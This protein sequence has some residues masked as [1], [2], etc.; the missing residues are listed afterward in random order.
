MFEGR[1]WGGS[2]DGVGSSGRAGDGLPL[3]F[4]F[5]Y[6]IYFWLCWVSVA[7]RAFPSLQR[8]RAPLLSCMGFSLYWLLLWSMGPSWQAAVVWIPRF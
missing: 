4:L 1:S 8:V 6:F 2:G 3:C 7:T 5:L